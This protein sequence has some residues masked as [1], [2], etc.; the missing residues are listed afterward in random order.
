[1]RNSNPPQVVGVIVVITVILSAIAFFVRR[2]KSLGSKQ[3]QQTS[4]DDSAD[5]QQQSHQLNP[6]SQNAGTRQTSTAAAAVDRNTSVRSVMTLPAY[7]PMASNNEQVLGREGERDG[8]DV[9]VDLP[10]AEDDEAL[11][12]QEMEALYQV[13]V[14]R[15]QMNAEREERRRQRQEAQARNDQTALAQIRAS[16]RAAAG[17]NDTL[18]ELRQNV[19]QVQE[20]RH[21]SVSSVSYG[22]LGVARHDGTR[23][24]ASSN[25]SERMGLLSDAASIAL[26]ARSGAHSPGLGSR[27]QRGASVSSVVSD[28]DSDFPSPGLTRPRT[29]SQGRAGSS[30]E[31]VEAHEAGPPPEY[32][33]VSLDDDSRTAPSVTPLNEPPPVYP[34]PNRS[35]SEESERGRTSVAEGPQTPSEAP[36]LPALRLDSLPEIHVIEPSSTYT[37][38]DV[39]TAARE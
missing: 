27:H 24:R 23:L 6:T 32:E 5:P 9:I 36:V 13:R 17:N 37:H 34:G 11:R 35:G 8:V 30:P 29:S 26:S 28:I 14:A 33:N 15:R 1:M 19:G 16:A 20:S 22:D 21:R 3:Y 7:R 10:T 31:L 25:D 18:N 2:K 39:D 38:N 4:G 12:D